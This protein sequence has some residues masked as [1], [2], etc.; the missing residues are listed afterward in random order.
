[1]ILKIKH[2]VYKLMI[3]L[4]FLCSTYYLNAQE[5]SV[6][7]FYLAETDLTANTPGTMV[8]DQNGNI[9]ALIKVETTLDGFT[10]DVGSLGIR[11]VK[12]IGGEMWVYVPFGI[13]KIS[14][15]H[16]KLGMIRDYALPTQIDQGRTYIL[17]LNA[18]L[19]NRIYDSNK[20]Q[21]MVLKVFP[22]NAKVEI[23][24]ISM[25][26]N[27]N[28]ICEQE[29]SFGIYE[30]IVSA[31]KYHTE[32]RQI[33]INDENNPQ[34]FDIHLKQAFGWLKI[35]GDGNEKLSIDGNAQNFI[36]NRGIE[37]MS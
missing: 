28:G 4:I 16:P 27:K 19:G 22:I 29:F 17:K 32:R 9:C 33:E 37:L 25:A 23:N 21:K 11:E 8:Y 6:K 1:M 5:M 13:R 14:I 35:S 36:P 2:I 31:S 18:T 20:K 15:S 10:F 30:V 24:G 7:S 12:R 34:Q 26:L 3:T